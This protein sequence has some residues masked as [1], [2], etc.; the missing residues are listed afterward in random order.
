[1]DTIYYA[2]NG[3]NEQ[4]FFELLDKFDGKIDPQVRKELIHQR[5]KQGRHYGRFMCVI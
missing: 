4:Y 3:T 1:M 5:V 2:V